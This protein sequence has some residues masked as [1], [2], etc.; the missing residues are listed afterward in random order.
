M[1]QIGKLLSN[2]PCGSLVLKSHDSITTSQKS[3]ELSEIPQW[4]QLLVQMGQDKRHD[5]APGI[6]SYW[7]EKLSRYSD[8]EVCAALR[9][10]A[11]EF[12]PAVDDITGV[13]ERRRKDAATNRPW[14]QFKAGQAQAAVE[15]KLATDEDYA[16]LREVFRRI[17]M[18]P[19]LSNG[20]VASTGPAPRDSD[21]GALSGVSSQNPRS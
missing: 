5:L 7:K 4:V 20:T 19:P 17:A 2:D 15:G 14:E 3:S 21:A 1:E 6:L 13:I 9:L 16:E 18:A 11:G 10:Y 12:F 8:S